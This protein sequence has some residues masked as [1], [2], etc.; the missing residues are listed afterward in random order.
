[1]T[2]RLPE[3]IAG[4]RYAKV[5]PVPVPAST[6]RCFLSRQRAFNG[7]RHLELALAVFVI[8]VPLGKQSFAAKELADRESFG[9]CSHLLTIFAWLHQSGLNVE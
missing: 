9:G 6:I 3:R 5:L 8:G 4:T 1:M 7:F 2:T